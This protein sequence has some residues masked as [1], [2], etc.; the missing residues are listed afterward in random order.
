[1]PTLPPPPV[2]EG[3][4]ALFKDYP[5]HIQT[6]QDDLNKVVSK[7]ILALI[8]SKLPFGCWKAALVALLLKLAKS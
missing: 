4:R 5:E 6:L 2:P 8:R 3:L 1:M 7:N